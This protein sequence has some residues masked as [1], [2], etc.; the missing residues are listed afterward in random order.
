MKSQ[1]DSLGQQATDHVNDLVDRDVD[2]KDS[3][4]RYAAYASRFRTALRAGSRYVAYVRPP[5]SSSLSLERLY[6]PV[7]SERLSAQS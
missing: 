3:D 5:R 7:T 4:L 2:S 1:K 6:R